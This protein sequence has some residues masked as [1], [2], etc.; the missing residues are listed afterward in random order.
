[1]K[2]NSDA[3][4]ALYIGLDVH[5]AETVIALLESHREAEPRH[6]GAIATTRHALERAMRSIARS[7]DLQLG[8]VRKGQ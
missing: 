5:K 4:Q 6:Y 3:P 7:R 2:S 8:P 1:M